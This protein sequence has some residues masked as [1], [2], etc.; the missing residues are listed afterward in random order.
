MC[1]RSGMRFD[2]T[3]PGNVSAVVIDCGF[4]IKLSAGRAAAYCKDKI[5]TENT[6]KESRMRTTYAEGVAQAGES[7]IGIVNVNLLPVPGPSLSAHIRPR[8]R[9]TRLL[10][11]DSPRPVP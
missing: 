8:C 3:V 11:R 6:W 9:S 5:E 7:T 10:V 4:K 2:S 1:G